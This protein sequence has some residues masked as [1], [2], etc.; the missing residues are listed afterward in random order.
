[1]PRP[2]IT[3]IVAVAASAR[4]AQIRVIGPLPL[5]FGVESEANSWLARARS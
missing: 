2:S 4:A 5:P 1:M 3:K